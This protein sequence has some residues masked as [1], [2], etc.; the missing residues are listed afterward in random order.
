MFCDYQLLNFLSAA[1]FCMCLYVHVCVC[2][3]QRSHGCLQL[4]F[5]FTLLSETGSFTEPGSHH[6]FRDRMSVSSRGQSVNS[7][8]DNL[9][10]SQI[11]TT[12]IGFY[13]LRFSY[14]RGKHFTHRGIFQAPST[15]LKNKTKQTNQSWE[16]RSLLEHLLI[17]MCKVLGLIPS[18]AKIKNEF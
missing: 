5:I 17:S 14:L 15:A 1:L 4:F 12:T 8:P 18:T 6:L 2:A 7:T 9:L 10:L 13:T 16:C 3:S 11:S